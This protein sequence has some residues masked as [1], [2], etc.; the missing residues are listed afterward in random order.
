VRINTFFSPPAALYSYFVYRNK[1]AAAVAVE[2][3]RMK[4]IKI[5]FPF[6]NLT[7]ADGCGGTVGGGGGGKEA[8]ERKKMKSA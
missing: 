8:D 3:D 5:S 2:N 7:M 6:E 1:V 4:I